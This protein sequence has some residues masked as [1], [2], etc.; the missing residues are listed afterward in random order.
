MIGNKIINDK[1]VFILTLII[2]VFS[3]DTMMFGTNESTFFIGMKYIVQILLCIAFVLLFIGDQS[4]R[5]VNLPGQNCLILC[6]VVV[7]SMMINR[8]IRS[9]YFSIIIVIVMSYLFAYY[10]EFKSF[11]VCLE[12]IVY[13]LSICSI[14]GTIVAKMVP[15]LLSYFPTI[16][17]SAGFEFSNGLVFVYS[18]IWGRSFGIFREPGVFQ[19]FIILGTIIYLY[20]AE[21]ISI[22]RVVI[23]SIAIILTYSTTGFIALFIVLLLYMV[24]LGKQNI[25]LFCSLIIVFCVGVGVLI[26]KTNVLSANGI[27]FSKFRNT[28]IMDLS[29]AARY[30]SVTS[31]LKM[32]L[33]NP[34]FGRGLSYVDSNFLLM[35]IRDYGINTG[36]NT[37]TLLCMLSTYGIFFVGMILNGYFKLVQVLSK[38]KIER[39]LI[40]LV[41]FILSCGERLT[42]SPI[43]YVL[44]FYGM[45]VNYEHR[46]F[47]DEQ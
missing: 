26:T 41:L 3:D 7:I 8:D 16:T 19:M 37:N 30:S 1:I 5:R 20:I 23:Y 6:T 24:K 28:G 40:A 11:F 42:F 33:T 25:K 2:I 13:V 18:D 22:F 10:V 12:K 47:S 36:S 27:V 44:C 29:A 46:R 21:K 14:I 38:R 45:Q 17:N 31:N 34:L 4:V 35:T 43:I 9:G 32:W 39:L 15:G